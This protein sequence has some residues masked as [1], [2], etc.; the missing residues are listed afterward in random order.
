MSTRNILIDSSN[1][2]PGTNNSKYIY[3]FQ[4][5]QTF[6]DSSIALNTLNMYYSWFNISSKL[7]NN[8]VFQYKWFNSSGSLADTFTVT[9]LDGFYSIT[10]INLYFQTVMLAN[11]HYLYDTVAKKNIFFY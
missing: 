2:V 1:V 7:Y 3:K 9:I 6:T 8:N 5:P 11:T 10:S 4:H